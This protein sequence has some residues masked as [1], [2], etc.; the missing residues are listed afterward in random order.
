VEWIVA[1]VLGAA[2]GGLATVVTAPD[3][4]RAAP[5][6]ALG[7][8]GAVLGDRLAGVLGLAVAGTPARWLLSV[9]AAALV[10]ALVRLLGGLRSPLRPA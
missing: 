8:V 2:V 6:V 9:V 3:R 7:I 5:F 4:G 10:I 1:I